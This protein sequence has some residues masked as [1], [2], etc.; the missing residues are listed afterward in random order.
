MKSSFKRF[1]VILSGIVGMLGIATFTA[2][3]AQAAAAKVSPISTVTTTTM[4]SKQM[5]LDWNY[6]VYLPAGYNPKANKRY[7]VLYMMHGLYGNHRNL[8]ERF[9]SQQ[10]LDGAMKRNNTKAIV[11][12]VDGFNSF[13]VNQKGGLQVESALMKDLVPKIDSTY[14]VSKSRKDHALGGV[15]MGGYA[16]ARLSLKYSNYFSKAIMVS[17]SVWYKLPKDNLIR[18]NMHAFTNG[19][20]NW[21]DQVYNGLFP[22]KY[23]NSKTKPVKFY[24]ETTSGDTTV[25]IKDV[26]H[27]VKDVKKDTN[28]VSIKYVK[29]TGDNHNWTYWTKATPKA[30]NWLM[31]EF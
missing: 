6:D 22:T 24:I 21:S 19:K 14:K 30:Y 9:N 25:P 4:Y 13:Y 2:T 3:N 7:P 20:T 31:N 26:N 27:F 15:S 10:M 23:I 12:F 18:Q 28:K 11:V 1:L 29:D 8:L 5:H 16:A 17:P